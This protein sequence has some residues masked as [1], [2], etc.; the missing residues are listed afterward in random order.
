MDEPIKDTEQDIESWLRVF[1]APR[2][3]PRLLHRLLTHFSHPARL[4]DAG[5]QALEALLGP[6]AASVHR[7][8][9]VGSGPGPATDLA[10]MQSSTDHH[11]LSLSDPRY[12]ELLK[13]IADPPLV[14]YVRGN[15]ESLSWPQV[16]IVGS[17]NP[18]PTGQETAG[19]FAADLSRSG[20]T[21]TS[22]MALGIDAAAHVG[23]LRSGGTTIAVA[24]TGLDRVYPARHDRLAS[25][26]SGGGA[27]ISEFPVGTPPRRAHFP[28]RNRLISGLSLGTLV[29]EAT[30]RSGSL[31]TARFA[32]EQGREVFAVPGS[33]YSPLARGC[34]ALIRDGAALAECPGDVLEELGCRPPGSMSR[35][36]MACSSTVAAP[37]QLL[38]HL[39]H[40][41]ATIDDLVRRSGLTAGTVCSMLLLLE[42]E[43]L[44]VSTPG[45]S[46]VRS[47][48]L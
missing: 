5:P 35:P 7:N 26:I 25:D 14:L 24:A 36:A 46:F 4:L 44:I 17:R 30:P 21:I 3:K 29:V 43:G 41:P 16:S 31:I 10:W 12:P 6:A 34:H 9:H 1:H 13:E 28:Q 20:Y 11:I 47:R 48:H 40:D 2:L 22:G 27:V 19:L 38:D 42:L 45:G 37:H 39:G 23:A 18:S 8:L 33:I 15:P 32:A